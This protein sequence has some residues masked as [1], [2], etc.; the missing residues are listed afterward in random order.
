MSP[1][2]GAD[3]SRLPVELQQRAQW[4]LA[5]PDKAPCLVGQTGLYN[6][7]PTMGP[8]LDFATACHYAQQYQ[9]HIG[10][11]LT[12]DDPFTCIDMD[13]KDAESRD[14]DGQVIPLE[15]RTP[16]SHLDFYSGVVQFAN[17]YTE[18][19]ASGKGLHVWV[20]GSIG[21]GRRGKG[22]EVY[23]QER[24][25]ICTGNSLAGMVYHNLLGKVVPSITLEGV[26]PVVNG[27]MIL[28][29]LVQEL[30]VATSS[31]ELTEVE[32]KLTDA[33]IWSRAT[34]A[35]NGEKFIDL[36]AG[37][38]QGHL[39]PSQS[40]ADLALMSMFTFYSKSNE[41]CR[42][43]FR[44]TELGKRAKAVQDDRYLDRTLQ[45]IRGR[46]AKELATAEHGAMIAATLLK[47]S[48][49]AEPRASLVAPASPQGAPIP[50]EE[51]TVNPK[52]HNFVLN[53]DQG[54]HA[55]PHPNE[56]AYVPPEVEGIP[57]PPGLV[58]AIAGFIY[59]S[60]PRPVK[61][62]AI[63]AA[64]G[65]M[66]GVTGKAYNIGQTGINLYIIL[67]ARSAIGKEAMH[68]GIGHILRSPCGVVLN[69]FVDYTDYASGPALTK[70]M[71]EF[72]SFVNVSGEWGRKLQRMADDRKEGPMQ[73]LRTVMTNLYQKSGAA[74]VMGG[75][76]Y[77]NREQ[78]VASVSAVAY[79]MIG[80]TTPGTFYDSLTQS[81]MEDGFLSRFN[82][83]EYMGERPP[84][85]KNQMTQVPEGISDAIASI[86]GHCAPI[87][88]GASANAIQIP[89]SPEAHAIVEAFNMEC[90]GNIRTAGGDESIRQIWNRAH[91]KAVRVAG[92]L[93]ASDNHT[94]PEIT[95]THIEWAISLIRT[96]A[97]SMLAKIQGGDI[98]LD[99]TARFRKLQGILESFIGGRLAGSYKV[100]PRMVKDG[101]IP[102]SYL[103]IRTSQI[104]CFQ[105]YRLG[106]TLALDHTIKTALDS[107]YIMEV[108][109]DKTVELYGYHGRC[110][111][112]LAID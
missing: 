1:V 78:N 6:A 63:V 45:I 16:Q 7:S 51:P 90:D 26:L 95:V 2:V 29:S 107:G 35:G 64:L 19:S 13:V 76:G 65:L 97:A 42:R 66:A 57:W 37:R 85:N 87:V 12:Q 47:N 21:A 43:M 105:N 46:Q 8:W 102:R 104:R 31:I 55:E 38:W 3:W 98:G 71:E 88:K 17:S 33:E 74:S 15:Q 61:E 84:E 14:K 50:S 79:S 25:I 106:A 67:I 62:V 91:L 81:M 48:R 80:E 9:C 30:G 68:S 89:Y 44:L 83:I 10:Y 11:I 82:I 41:Q 34:T 5:G 40:E 69:R 108:S 49:T 73:Q 22:M 24:F 36:C 93:A 59:Q 4:C 96:D 52:V 72:P 18:L 92:V 27:D 32:Q 54:Q 75:L 109:K 70:A 60:A 99:D 86:A 23:S 77:S 103:Q 53:L 101:L 111:R 39:F 28:Q 94:V 100:D 58:G 110:F 56:V 20:H 112:V